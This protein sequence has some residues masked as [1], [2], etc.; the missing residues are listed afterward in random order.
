[1][2]T[3]PI[4]FSGPM[5]RA[6]L[7]GS[8]TQT[9]G[10]GMGEGGAY[11]AC[12]P[13]RTTRQ[14]GRACLRGKTGSKGGRAIAFLNRV[15]VASAGRGL[16]RGNWGAWEGVTGVVVRAERRFATLG[17]PRVEV[18]FPRIGGF[19]PR[20]GFCSASPFSYFSSSYIEREKGK[21]GGTDQQNAIPVLAH[22]FPVYEKLVTESI[23]G[24]HGPSP[25]F[26]G[27]AGNGDSLQINGLGVF[28]RQ[29]P[30]P[31]EEMPPSP[32]GVLF[33]GGADRGQ[34]A[35]LAHRRME[36]HPSHTHHHPGAPY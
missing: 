24:L 10:L 18:V 6:L 23:P 8:K 33:F 12:K 20:V 3:R 35:R 25:C 15:G 17:N 4:L 21:E 14:K 13:P 32:L 1:M 5:V 11:P 36:A 30:H 2:K 19:F 9:R 22:V 29:S 31:R 7:D 28:R 26:P 16:T 34:G 27:I